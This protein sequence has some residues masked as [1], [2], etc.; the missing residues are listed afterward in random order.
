MLSKVHSGGD[1]SLLTSDH[2]I[3]QL[4]SIEGRQQAEQSLLE[5]V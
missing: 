1:Q 5:M 3:R 2:G 4:E